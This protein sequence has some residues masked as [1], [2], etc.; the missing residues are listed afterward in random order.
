MKPR[1]KT[2]PVWMPSKEEMEIIVSECETVGQI[3]AKLG[4]RNHGSNFKTLTKRFVA[5]GI[6]YVS[7]KKEY[8]P[9][10]KKLTPL[11][12]V[13]VEHSTYPRGSLKKRLI[14]N[15][16]LKNQCAKCGLG[17]EWDGER[18][19]LVLDH[20]NG[21]HDDN[22]IHN[23]RLLC[24]N[25]NS[26]TD[27]FAGRRNKVHKTH[28]VTKSIGNVAKIVTRRLGIANVCPNCAKWKCAKSTLCNDCQ[29][30]SPKLARRKT[31]RPTAEQLQK[32]LWDVPTVEIAKAH[33]VSDKAVGKWARS[34]GLAKP[35][36]GYW[37]KPK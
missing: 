6:D 18:L 20:I 21:S 1:K 2:S 30:R 23:L 19:V 11:E 36:R 24:P 5:D 3:L 10:I 13:L 9:R 27:T 32:L 12:D 37:S 15:G 29:N 31:E 33:G 16:M 14:Q 4:M 28:V 8:T 7:L 25:C 26:Q 17:T 34:Y 35:P 22:R